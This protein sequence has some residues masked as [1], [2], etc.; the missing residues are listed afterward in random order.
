MHSLIGEWDLDDVIALPLL[1]VLP[2]TPLLLWIAWSDL[3]RMRI[4][5]VTVLAIMLV[6][7]LLGPLALEV[8]DWGWRLTH[9]PIVLVLGFVL[10]VAGV[11]G[12][13][14]AK[15]LAALAPFVAVRDVGSALL[16]LAVAMVAGLVLH[17]IVR[18]V[19]VM[20]RLAPGWASWTD[21]AFPMGLSISAAMLVYI[22]IP[23]A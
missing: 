15:A 2:L 23:Y 20:R 16:V 10:S 7:L 22:S 14:D 8:R 18:R 21:G 12:A 19:G 9:L 1:L 17:R 11:L 3:A 5:N 4:R 13:G 6:F